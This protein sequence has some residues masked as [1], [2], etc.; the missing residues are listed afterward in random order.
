MLMKRLHQKKLFKEIKHKIAQEKTG[1]KN[2]IM[3]TFI[4]MSHSISNFKSQINSTT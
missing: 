3:I 1:N 4:C 2:R